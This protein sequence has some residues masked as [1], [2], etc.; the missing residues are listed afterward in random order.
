MIM[1][2]N[3]INSRPFIF[4]SLFLL[5]LMGCSDKDAPELPAVDE[6]QTDSVYVKYMVYPQSDQ[7][8]NPMIHMIVETGDWLVSEIQ[9]PDA[10]DRK[11]WLFVN[12]KE[13][14]STFVIVE[15]SMICMQDYDL[16]GGKPSDYAYYFIQDENSDFTAYRCRLGSGE[17]TTEILE[18][19]SLGSPD[20]ASTVA[21]RAKKEEDDFDDTRALLDKHLNNLF[22]Q[23]G[24]WGAITGPPGPAVSG[25]W[26][27]MAAPVAKMHLYSNDPD[28]IQEIQNEYVKDAAIGHAEGIFVDVVV[29]TYEA[30][31]NG[32]KKFYAMAK[33]GLGLSDLSDDEYED[34]INSFDT[35]R[36]ESNINEWNTFSRERSSKIEDVIPE[37]VPFVIKTT[38]V[39]IGYTD[40]CANI[41]IRYNQGN[42]FISESGIVL[43]DKNGHTK[44]FK[45]DGVAESVHLTGLT[46]NSFY[47]AIA[48]V[49]SYGCNYVGNEVTF[50]TKVLDFAVDPESIS[51]GPE[52][53]SRAVSVYLPG[54]NWTWEISK[55]PSWCKITKAAESFFVDV[56][57]YSSTR[58]GEIVVKGRDKKS[59]EEKQCTVSVTQ[60]AG[61]HFKG[62][63]RIEYKGTMIAN[64]SSDVDYEAFVQ[65][66]GDS[67][68][69]RCVTPLSHVLYDNID[70]K[71]KPSALE[72][73]SQIKSYSHDITSDGFVVQGETI[74]NYESHA[75]GK[76]RISVDLNAGTFKIEDLTRC[77]I[78]DAWVDGKCSGTVHLADSSQN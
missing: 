26:N 46:Q 22:K 18:V 51:F 2:K 3:F 20:E 40:A 71:Q 9:A 45:Y 15:N 72:E 39:D 63:I 36:V 13:N 74:G 19:I 55:K 21:S 57:A 44:T 64:L 25:V 60:S 65:R 76:F 59:G 29:P 24:N 62:K 14:I 35:P 52:K 17:N 53:G 7:G 73:Q 47:R 41:K 30:M 43:K 16:I 6:N 11:T 58:K 42:S 5:I 78:E 33:F 28:K 70:I 12:G 67:Y 23:T 1:A 34:Y 8:S 27:K 56:N 32:I 10:Y 66:N 54:V 37:K 75:T 31:I 77:R 48:Y 50:R 49:K 61:Y 4:I 68:L 38:I 69:L